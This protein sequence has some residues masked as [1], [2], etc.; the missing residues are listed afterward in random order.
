MTHQ[1]FSIT[2]AIL[3][4]INNFLTDP[5]NASLSDLRRVVSK[6]G[7]VAEINEKACEAGK[8]DTLVKKLERIQCSYVKDLE[9]L[10]GIKEEGRF[11]S[12]SEYRS[13]IAPDRPVWSYDETKA[14][15]LEI[16]ALQYFPWLIAE[17]KQAIEKGEILPGRFIRVRKMKEQEADNGDLPAVRAAIKILGASCVETLDTKGTDGSNIHLGGPATITGYFGGIGQPNGHPLKWIDEVLYYYVNYGVDE[18]LNINP[19]T[20]FLG[21]LLYKLGVNIRFKISVFMGND[22]PYAVLWTL[23]AARLFAREDGSTPLAGFNLSNSIDVEHLAKAAAIRK[24]LKLE[25]QV[26]IEHHITET[27]KS[28]V[29]QPYNRRE[30]LLKLV[31]TIPNISAKHEGG[32]PEDEEQLTHPSDILDYF[33]DKKEIEASGDWNAL[34]LNY[35]LKHKAVNSTAEALTKAGFSFIAAGVHR[36]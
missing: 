34:S 15:T 25:E 28:I 21:Y 36:L 23:L 22:N 4:D 30:D 17:A 24:E 20:V 27:W 7:T 8:I 14:P 5:H 29:L 35:L 13:R 11:I 31:E 32:N 16:S 33:R 12:L 6:Y 2:P 3:E 18:V 26:R 9:W 1:E 19:G 10:A